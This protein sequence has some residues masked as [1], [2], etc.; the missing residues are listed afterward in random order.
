MT[1]ACCLVLAARAPNRWERSRNVAWNQWFHKLRSYRGLMG[2]AP[3][4]CA[5]QR[6]RPEKEL[7]GAYNEKQPL[8]A[9]MAHT[10][11]GL[12]GRSPRLAH[13]A[14]GAMYAPPEAGFGCAS[15]PNCWGTKPECG[16]ESTVSQIALPSRIGRAA[17]TRCAT[18]AW[19]GAKEPGETRK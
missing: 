5:A 19:R 7:G 6:R 12:R 13:I 11:R 16:L 8:D 14:K 1:L 2:P 15:A 3:K 17:R 10:H 4:R 9:H 18:R